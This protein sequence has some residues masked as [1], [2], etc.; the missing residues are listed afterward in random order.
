MSR[1]SLCYRGNVENVFEVTL[2]GKKEVFKNRR[3]RIF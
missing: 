1:V 2:T 3:K